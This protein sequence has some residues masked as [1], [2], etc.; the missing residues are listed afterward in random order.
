M[1]DKFKVVLSAAAYKP[2][3][4]KEIEKDS[5]G[6]YKVRLG[7]FNVFNAKN[8]FYISKGVDDLIN[9]PNSIF[10]RRLKKGYLC[11]EMGHPSM[12]PGM[13]IQQFI[14]R[15]SIIDQDNIAF[16][17][18]DIELVDTGEKSEKLGMYGNVIICY[19]WIKPAGPKGKYLQ[20]ALDNPD[21]NIAFSVRSVS[22]DFVTNGITIKETKSIAT[23]DWVVE[24]GINN[25]N[26]FDMLN[27]RNI[28]TESLAVTITEEDIKT[29]EASIRSD[30]VNGT[31]NQE[32]AEDVIEFAEDIRGAF[33][34]VRERGMIGW[35]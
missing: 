34:P 24:P 29:M 11:G 17:I 5:S 15:S 9:N 10:Y 4:G 25:A 20:E 12:K 8:A 2:M 21:R 1:E 35:K 30:V 13:S 16:H 6:Y 18:R 3:Q 32:S 31:I 26:T 14:Y 28:N 19:G 23:W 7:A 33:S 22:K 27:N